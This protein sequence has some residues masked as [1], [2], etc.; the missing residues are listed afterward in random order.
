M[1]GKLAEEILVAKANLTNKPLNDCV[2]LL[3]DEDR[4]L[5]SESESEI[6]PEIESER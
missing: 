5:S 3:D 4:E 6:E 1:S 2:T